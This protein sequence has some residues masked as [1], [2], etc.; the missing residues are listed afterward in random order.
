[1][2]PSEEDS[3]NK[4][5]ACV[6][7]KKLVHPDV[8]FSYPVAPKDKISKPKS[9]DFVED[10]RKSVLKNAYLHFNE[11]VSELDIENKQ[12]SISV[13]ESADILHRLSLKS[14]EAP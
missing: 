5:P 3:C 7:M 10:W 8:T 2:N 14:V 4:C 9:V 13:D 6:K 11:W 1:E 12:G